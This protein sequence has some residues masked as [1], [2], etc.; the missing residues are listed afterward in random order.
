MATGTIQGVAE[1][2]VST[3]IAASDAGNVLHSERSL[4]T[5]LVILTASV[6]DF[7]ALCKIFSEFSL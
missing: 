5:K 3:G 1:I 2:K 7:Y 4:P 6:A